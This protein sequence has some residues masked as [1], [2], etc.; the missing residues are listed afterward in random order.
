MAAP[1]H[2]VRKVRVSPYTYAVYDVPGLPDSGRC[3]PDHESIQLASQQADNQKRD[4]L[5]HES[6]H[7]I[8]AQGMSASL[9]ELDKMLE[10]T[11]VSFLAPR[12]L[13]LMRDNPR[14]VEYLTS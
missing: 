7:A 8:I 14:L 5:L 13:A 12:L 9:K 1:L 10:E 4:T 3:H 6:I 2:E 11:L